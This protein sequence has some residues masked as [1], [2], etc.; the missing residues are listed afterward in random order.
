[1]R[2]ILFIISIIFILSILPIS[3]AWD[4]PTYQWI[5]VKLC[6]YYNCG[7]YEEII[8]GSLAP[9]NDFQPKSISVRES[10]DQKC[11]QHYYNPITCEPSEFYVCPTEY[12][13]IA[14]R[15][16][17]E[18]INYAKVDEGCEMWYDIGVASHYFFVSKEIWNQ[19][20]NASYDC[21]TRF[22]WRVGDMF[23]NENEGW[24][25]SECGENVADFQFNEWMS[26]FKEKLYFVGNNTMPPPEVPDKGIFESDMVLIIV[27]ICA[28]IFLLIL[29]FGM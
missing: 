9:D 13:D 10:Q 24:V 26:E 7:C 2:K 27:I 15:K 19:V 25:I 16:T 5:S 12:D 21:K 17:D 1:M 22:E 6:D 14:I 3:Y 23:R 20:I 4:S 8:N 11:C 29:N 18:W 28:F